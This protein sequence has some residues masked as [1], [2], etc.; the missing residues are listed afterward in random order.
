[1]PSRALILTF[2]A[3]VLSQLTAVQA[4]ARGGLGRTPGR[5]YRAEDAHDCWTADW[6]AGRAGCRHRSSHGSDAAMRLS[7]MV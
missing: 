4:L 5:V 3:T 1:M 6:A 7:Y 2:A